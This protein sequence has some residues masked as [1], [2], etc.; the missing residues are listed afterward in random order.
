M[1]MA[2]VGTTMTMPAAR[3]SIAQ[4]LSFNNHSTMCTFS[5]FLMQSSMVVHV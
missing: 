2:I 3:Q 4:Q 5:N 1:A